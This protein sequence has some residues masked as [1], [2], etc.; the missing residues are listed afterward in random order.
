MT[1]IIALFS[2]ERDGR[3]LGSLTSEVQLLRAPPQR[4]TQ[5]GLD[6]FLLEDLYVIVAEVSD[7]AQRA[8]DLNNPALQRAT[9]R[10]LVNPLVPWIWYGGLI[11]VVGT[12]IALWPG[13]GVPIRRPAPA[14]V[15]AAVG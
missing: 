13:A 14:P 1:Q 9:I 3:D 7:Q 12:L 6:H 2:V 4:T 11:V 15:P 8:S 10:V 5:V